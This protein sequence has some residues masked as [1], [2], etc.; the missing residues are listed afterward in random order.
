MSFEKLM[1]I[2][3]TGMNAQLIRMN[4]TASN[5]ANAGVVAGTDAG[6]FR[7]KRPVFE[8]LLNNAMSGKESFEGGVRVNEIINDPKPVK[9]VFEPNNPL[10]DDNGYVFASNVNEIEEL[11]EM[12]DASRAYQNNVEVISTAKQLMSRTLEV[13]KV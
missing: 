2:A 7:A 8:S 11:I 5:L 13:I 6:A 9:Q 10:A 12:M 1:S 3:G 4:T